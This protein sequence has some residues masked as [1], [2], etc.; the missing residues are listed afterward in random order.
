M[1]YIALFISLFFSSIVCGQYDHEDVF[2]ELDDDALRQSILDSYKTNTVL[3]YNRARDTFF[4]QIDAVDNVLECVYSGFKI[5]LNPDFDPTQDAFAKGINT[6]HAYPR[7]KGALEGTMAFSDM[8][9]LFPAKANINTDRGVLPFEEVSDSQTDRWYFEN[10][11]LTSIPNQ[12]R[13][14]YSELLSGSGFEPREKHKGD[15]ARAYFYFYTMYQSQTDQADPD[16]FELQR[17][18]LCRWHFLDP[19]D[20]KEWNRNIKI[21][22]YQGDN[23]NPFILDCRLAR[24]YCSDIDAACISVSTDEVD[25]VEISSYPNPASDILFIEQSNIDFAQYDLFNMVGNRIDVGY[26]LSEN[27]HQS[28]D[29][30]RLNTGIYFLR[31]YDN[32]K[33]IQAIVKFVKQ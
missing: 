22:T 3:S 31:L 19:V 26:I 17:E 23:K 2:L 11:V 8:Y 1:K 29:I 13:D 6:E 27:E 16:F 18:E 15:I 28:I 32:Q 5:T 20:E 30:S 4:S 21:S 12:N 7:S 24:L 33:G 25:I 9:N 10:D 14:L